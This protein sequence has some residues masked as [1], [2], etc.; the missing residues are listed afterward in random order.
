VPKKV[1][2]CAGVNDL[3]IVDSLDLE[4]DRIRLTRP[5]LL[6][7]DIENLALGLWE[8]E[9]A[10][11]H[12]DG[13]IFGRVLAGHAIEIYGA[14]KTFSTSDSPVEIGIE[15][16]EW[17][18]FIRTLYDTARRTGGFQAVAGGMRGKIRRR[19]AG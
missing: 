12:A 9:I 19:S 18:V 6:K 4:S 14:S 8:H 17:F 16:S 13:Q 5:I 10:L 15:D 1:F 11:L 3:G 2:W 7:S